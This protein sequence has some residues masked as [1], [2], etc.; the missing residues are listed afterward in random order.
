[1]TL[2]LSFSIFPLAPAQAAISATL[3]REL[4]TIVFEVHGYDGRV[5]LD[6]AAEQSPP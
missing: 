2:K 4:L 5:E 1:M 3:S 6:I